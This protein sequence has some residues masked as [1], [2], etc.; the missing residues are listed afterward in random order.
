MFRFYK[1]GSCASL[2]GSSA[3]GIC[4]LSFFQHVGKSRYLVFDR[5]FQP[6]EWEPAG[7]YDAHHVHVDKR[8]VW[9]PGVGRDTWR[10]KER[11]FF[12]IFSFFFSIS[13]FCTVVSVN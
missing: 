2:P 6:G 13:L 3:Q 12:S 7:V 5:H 10:F 11:F 9:G 1:T 4:Y 8:H